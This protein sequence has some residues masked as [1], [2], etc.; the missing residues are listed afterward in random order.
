MAERYDIVIVGGGAAGC[1]LAS[2][3]SERA[4]CSVLLLEAG[5]D[6]R[7]GAEPA[8][9]LSVAPLSYFNSAYKW[10]L[11]AYPRT[12][13]SSQP[14]RI[15]QG[16]ILGGGSSVMG[17]VALRGTPDDYDEWAALGAAGWAWQDVLP[18][19][20]KLERDADFGGD[21]HGQDGP[22]LIRR[23][24]PEQWPPLSHAA[25]D[26][27]AQ[28]QLPF[29]ADMNGDF[30][31]GFCAVPMA[32]TEEKRQ[33]AAIC[34]LDAAVRAR[35]NLR[36][37]T[38]ATVQ[39]LRFEGR[40]AVGV[41][42]QVKGAPQR[43]D[44]AQVIVS[45]GALYTPALLMRAGIGPA[46]DLRAL[47]IAVTADVPGVG[48]NLQN[49]PSLYFCGLVR[50]GSEQPR[51][52]KSQ[53]NASLRFSSHLPGCPPADMFA[54][55]LSKT[56]WHAL[57]HKLATLTTVVHKPY[58]R[59]RVSLRSADPAAAPVIEFNYLDDARDL[60]RLALGTRMIAELAASEEV[61]AHCHTFFPVFVTDRLRKLNQPTTANALKAWAVATLLDVAP[62]LSDRV[63]AMIGGRTELAMLAASRER[64]NAHI[65]AN[66]S[67][68]A[69]YVGTCRMGAADDPMAVVDT[70]GRV[71]GVEGLRV[72]D[73]SVMPRIPR[74]NTNIPTL[75]VAEKMA[76]AIAAG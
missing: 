71:R 14:L 60:E 75:M 36:I 21:L 25:R 42:A 2:R 24:T 15:A 17:M 52:L 73:A 9:V 51:A 27:F 63:G 12:R 72:V 53:N 56:S 41:D 59:G 30:R 28:R 22:T 46:A 29:V 57:G 68:T 18:V 39:A 49:H 8:D 4:S 35:P 1:V 37:E 20:R 65:R 62:W 67:G 32:A 48:A 44:A 5:C 7:P 58:S 40:R 13:E 50:R 69:H 19:F 70:A 33:S 3:L 61:R 23:H 34:Y 47:G 16:R 6:M 66:V 10:P 54:Q 26:Y 55:V 45:A 31:D 43:I 64:L 76:A 38:G 74:A 11:D